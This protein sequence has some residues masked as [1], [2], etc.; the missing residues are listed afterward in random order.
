LAR[1]S[2]QTQSSFVLAV[3]TSKKSQHYANVAP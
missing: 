3:C 1:I 2:R